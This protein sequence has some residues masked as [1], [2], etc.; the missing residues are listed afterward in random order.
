MIFASKTTV[1]FSMLMS[2]VLTG[3]EHFLVNTEN[4]TGVG[5]NVPVDNTHRDYT[6]A[7]VN[8]T[9]DEVTC[10]HSR[11]IFEC[12]NK[13]CIPKEWTCDGQDNCGDGTDEDGCGPEKNGKKYQPLHTAVLPDDEL[14]YELDRNDV[15]YYSNEW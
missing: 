2:V 5:E 13:K 12:G 8:K 15:E 7:Q 11:G 3:P 10:S 4:N 14:S 1:L 6:L 9:E